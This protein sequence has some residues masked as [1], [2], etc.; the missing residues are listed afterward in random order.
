VKQAGSSA[1]IQ[2][3]LAVYRVS[4]SSLS[5]QKLRAAIWHWDLLRKH[6]KVSFVVAS[7]GFIAYACRSVLMRMVERMPRWRR[8]QAGIPDRRGAG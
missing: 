2:E 7:A 8:V 6:M 3:P 1:G 4:S 5:G